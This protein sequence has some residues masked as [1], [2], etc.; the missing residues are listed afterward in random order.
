VTYKGFGP[1][2]AS[3]ECP[4]NVQIEYAAA[5]VDDME[6]RR[7]SWI[8]PDVPLTSYGAAKYGN[9]DLRAPFSSLLPGCG[10]VDLSMHGAYPYKKQELS[11]LKDEIGK[12]VSDGLGMSP[13]QFDDLVEEHH[14]VI[15][16][17][18]AFDQFRYLL[19][20]TKPMEKGQTVA[21]NFPSVKAS[22]NSEQ[23]S[24][25]V[26]RCMHAIDEAVR[27]LCLADLRALLVWLKER[28]FPSTGYCDSVA[29]GTS[30]VPSFK[31]ACER[32]RRLHWVTLR[33]IAA[34][35]DRRS[36]EDI[37]VCKAL[38]FGRQ[39]RSKQDEWDK[40]NQL[41]QADFTAALGA[42][43]EQEIKYALELDHMCGTRQ[44]S[45][46]CSKARDLFGSVV[47]AAAESYLTP[48]DSDSSQWSSL[49]ALLKDK[50]RASDFSNIEVLDDFVLHQTSNAGKESSDIMVKLMSQS[51][52]G[53]ADT[54]VHGSEIPRSVPKP[55]RLETVACVAESSLNG[56]SSVVMRPTSDVRDGSASLSTEWYRGHFWQIVVTVITSFRLSLASSE[57]EDRDLDKILSSVR[58][59]VVDD[60]IVKDPL[61][62]AYKLVLSA[63]SLQTD[64]YVPSS[65]EFFLGLVWPALRKNGWRLIAGSSPWEV[66]FCPKVL[67][68]KRNGSLKQHRD[69]KRARL[70]NE[71]NLMGLGVVP[72]ATKRLLVAVTGS[73]DM[74]GT[75]DV[76]TVDAPDRT[77]KIV[78]DRFRSW[79]INKF[80]SEEDFSKVFAS[81]KIIQ[82]VRCIQNCFDACAAMLSPV[83]GLP[84]A[85]KEGHRPIEVYRCEY[86]AQFLLLLPSALRHAELSSQDMKNHMDIVGDLLAYLAAYH[87]EIFDKRFHPPQEEYVGSEKETR[88]FLEANIHSLLSLE[89]D[90]GTEGIPASNGFPDDDEHME[91]LLDDD[92]NQLTDFLV[93]VLEQA[94]VFRATEEDVRKKNGRVQLGSPGLVCRHCMG[95]KH[96][97]RYFFSS[98][99]SLTSSY[100]V[101]EKHYLKCPKTPADVK[102]RLIETRSRHADQR[103]T[104]ANGSQQAFFTRLWE[105]FRKVKRAASKGGGI[106]T[107]ERQD[108]DPSEQSDD[109]LVFTDHIALLDHC[110]LN[111]KLNS[112]KEVVEA[113]DRYY[114]CL[115][116]AGRVYE[117]ESMPKHFSANWLLSKVLPRGNHHHSHGNVG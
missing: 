34:I 70:A 9:V 114:S 109:E 30:S 103:K 85:L 51:S 60:S 8:L 27:T 38:Y 45:E 93:A 52:N 92:K 64:E 25:T 31:K 76:D 33:V 71:V 6:I 110:R 7:P 81:A 104:L 55:S 75:I 87:K 100:T 19:C 26:F 18:V 101:L 84:P 77:V 86:L 49:A 53:L 72:K 69:L 48:P 29:G 43:V 41:Q 36:P 112:N 24:H 59:I 117:T 99:E 102:L 83:P 90:T 16:R 12:F 68:R 23:Y 98:S 107:M 80:A 67:T 105:R 21:L 5:D 40:L 116:Y 113:L 108:V 63:P 111:S 3:T 42:Q 37:E 50:V 54:M 88:S 73:N 39:I 28:V 15:V 95:H 91:L 44:R 10:L 11:P 96:E 46:F 20:L 94:V 106:L 97:G 13:A 65:Y 61:P 58:P 1:R 62:I 22:L 17:K 35:G 115:D 66:S 57:T 14:N 2:V 79:L 82:V 4:Q 74:E 56:S 32:R 78:L 89:D 47:K